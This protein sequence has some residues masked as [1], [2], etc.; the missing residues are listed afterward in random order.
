ML[1]GQAAVRPAARTD[2][3]LREVRART[4]AQRCR[5]TASRTSRVA[6]RPATF[7][8]CCRRASR[9]V[10]DARRWHAAGGVRLAAARRQRRAR[11]D[12]PHV[13]LRS[14]HDGLRACRAM[15]TA[16]SRSCAACGETATLIGE[17]APRRPRRRDRR[18]SAAD[19]AAAASSCWSRAAAATCGR[20]PSA[21]PPA[22]CRSTIARSSATAPT[23]ARSRGPRHGHATRA[24]LRRSISP[25][26]TLRRA[27]SPTCVASYAPRLVVLAGFMRILG[28]GRSCDRFAGRMLN[29]HPSL[30]PQSPRPAHPSP[31]ARGRRARARCERAF[32]HPRTRR[33]PGGPTGTGPGAAGRRRGD[34]CSTRAARRNT[35]SIPQCI[36]WF[37]AGRLRFH[38]GAAWLDGRRLDTPVIL[39]SCRR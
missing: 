32:R 24:V 34:S 22:S 23:P 1:D 18:M 10:I 7:R 26:A 37:A 38:D 30:L 29:I 25:I 15:R 5:C 12:V 28:A 3:H 9:R 4:A 8:A 19:A 27:R 13:Q 31:R 17:V 16:R 39:G 35:G 33:R 21:A 36:G 14:R 2:A 6:A 20:S 11:R